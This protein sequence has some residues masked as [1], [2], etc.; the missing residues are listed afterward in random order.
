[1]SS[2]P[3]NPTSPAPPTRGQAIHAVRWTLAGNIG[4]RVLAFGAVA[5]LAR[6]L[7]ETEFGAYRQLLAVHL[8]LFVLLPLGFDQLYIREV[9]HRR[10]F[11]A[12]LAGTLTLTATVTAVVAWAGHWTFARWM[13]FG[14]WS[15]L[16]WGFPA[17]VALQS[18]KLVYKTDLA[19]RLA[20]RPISLGEMLYAGVTGGAGVALALVWPVAASLY[21]AYGLAELIE[22]W[23][24]RRAAS[25]LPGT[26]HSVFHLRSVARAVRLLLLR[27]WRWR[28]FALF[29]CGNQGLNALGGNAPVIIFGSALS[30]A[31]AASFSMANW[32][33]TIPIYILIGALH[34]VAFSA[35]AGRDR[36]GLASPV[37]QMLQLA[38][39]FIVPVLIVVVV[40]AEPLI[41]VV[42]GTRWVDSTAPVAR[43]LSLYCIF[44]ALF[45]P[46]SSLD[47]LLDRPDYG[48]YWNVLATFVRIVAVLAGLQYGVMEAVIA[49]AV[50]SAALWLLW[51][52]MLAQLLG[53]GQWVFHRAWLA[54]VPLWV[55]YAG[56]LWAVL[57]LA[58]HPWAQ[59]ILCAVPSLAYA[60]LLRFFAP[61]VFRQGLQLVRRG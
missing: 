49:Y 43:Y 48:F 16:L 32:L 29:H 19:A 7:S 2:Q 54:F 38:A 15:H 26:R 27:G 4:Q 53:A 8:V 55:A 33:V 51:G 10:K 42:L 46:V 34:R 5:V 45:S 61:D 30:K 50:A 3:D 36:A 60:A 9:R 44:S 21:V 37:L 22:W 40:M 35:L 20:Y 17:V 56:G 12:L 59:L 58:G 28:R 52:A 13:D 47:I 57:M 24:L 41:E 23:W 18:A 31:A 11:A 1:M 14:P 39:A 25:R 6:L